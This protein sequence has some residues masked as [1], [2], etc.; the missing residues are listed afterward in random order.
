[1]SDGGPFEVW[2]VE[3]AGHGSDEWHI[4]DQSRS[5]GTSTAILDAIDALN[6]TANAKVLQFRARR[7]TP[8]VA[9]ETPEEEPKPEPVKDPKPRGWGKPPAA[10]KF[11]WFDD[12]Q[13]S[14]CGRWGF[15]SDY[16]PPE[17]G[18]Y[19]TKDLDQDCAGCWKKIEARLGKE[20]LGT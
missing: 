6:K 17:G 5:F 12:A 1:M 8:A 15:F 2:V 16:E 11:H 13:I 14:I 7:Y 19:G 10:Q 9:G 18:G 3:H 4:W 20:A